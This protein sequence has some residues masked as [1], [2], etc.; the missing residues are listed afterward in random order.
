MTSLCPLALGLSIFAAIS[1][2]ALPRVHAASIAITNFSFE[3]PV[4]A[5]DDNSVIFD[6]QTANGYTTI[7]PTGGSFCDI[8]IE[9]PNEGYTGATGRGTPAGADGSQVLFINDNNFG[10]KAAIYQNVGMLLANTTYTFTVAIGARTDRTNEAGYLTLINTAT[11]VTTDAGT[12]LNTTSGIS[13]VPGSFQDFSTTY[14]TGATVSGNLTIELYT[15]ENGDI[16]ASF[17]NLRLTATSA[18]PEPSSVAAC[19][20]GAAG[21]AGWIRSRR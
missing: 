1:T 21:I 2:A 15:I 9:N 7:T 16:Q 19:L 6:N 17:D 8:G 14:T 12:T 13:S 18:V 10:N 11:G 3:S 20:V 5:N 4:Q